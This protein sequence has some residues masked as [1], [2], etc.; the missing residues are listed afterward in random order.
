MKRNTLMR[1]ITL[2]CLFIFTLKTSGQDTIL[3]YYIKQGLANNLRLQQKQSDYRHSL[4]VLKESRSLF[5]PDT[6]FQARYTV[7]EGGRTIDFP[8][9]DLLNPVYRTLN[10]LT[11]TDQFPEIENESF[12]FYRPREHE[13]KISLQQP[14]FNPHIYFNNKIKSQLSQIK[15][16]DQETYQ[17]ELVSKIK[18]S[19]YNYLKTKEIN[20]VLHET[21][22]VL[23]ENMR[24][25]RSLY[26]N[27]KI[28]LDSLYAAREMLSALQEEQT[29]NKARQKSARSY[30]NFLLNRE[31]NDIIKSPDTTKIEYQLSH[32]DS[33]IEEALQTREEIDGLKASGK[34]ISQQVRLKKSN[35]LPTL[36][37]MI[38]YGFQGKNYTFTHEY[39]FLL[40]S[41]VL[42]W[43]LFHGLKNKHQIEQAQIQHQKQKQK[44]EEAK[45]KI[46]LEVSNAY[47]ELEAAY[48]KIIHQRDAVQTHQEIFHIQEKKHQHG[49]IPFIQYSYSRNQ[50]TKAEQKLILAKYDFLSKKADL[51][52][53]VASYQFN[54]D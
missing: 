28:T 48:K 23:K 14:L 33:Q 19:Y 22:K 10:T 34:A 9:G 43:D 8:V 44:L 16:A 6:D 29:K 41:V 2:I 40:A 54:K 3:N 49:Q 39:D 24:V 36:S 32:L 21:E 13:T 52:R 53:A 37:T 50:L 4:A 30:F 7:A 35:H 42:K 5:Y 51:E 45:Q 12:Y 25:A 11:M 27:E 1:I 15:K 47:Y 46:S 18:K 20:K 26:R 17:R 38:D 31:L